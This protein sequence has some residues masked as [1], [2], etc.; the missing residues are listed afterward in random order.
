MAAAPTDVAPWLARFEALVA[1]SPGPVPWS[2][3]LD[4]HEGPVGGHVVVGS[5]IH[6]VETG[7]LPAAV[8]VLEE[9]YDRQLSFVGR[10]TVFVGN[11]AAV[12]NGSRYVEADLNRVF[13]TDAPDSLEARRAAEL[14]PLLASASIFFDFHQTMQPSLSPFYIFGFHEGS[15]LWAR[16]V[17]GSGL[18]VTRDGRQPFSSGSLC[19]DE[20]CRGLGIPAVT[21]ELGERGLRPEAERLAYQ[22]LRA[23]LDWNAVLAHG[24][25]NGRDDLRSAAEARPDF[26][27]YSTVHREP[28]D[29]GFATLDPG[30]SNFHEVKAGERLGRKR[31]T[32]ITSPIDGVI[33]FPKYPRR[34]AR[35]ACLDPVAGELFHVARLLSEHPRALWG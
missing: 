35:G 26:H 11:P 14:R 1:R 24:R 6:G 4:G 2:V 16:L 21:L 10:L 29:D 12:R 30:L 22:T 5:C 20:Y 17:G 19:G 8:R 25:K 13:A 23:L 9:A 3:S 33:L 7:S 31:N 15:Y 34:D 27:F 32:L 28:F 18:L